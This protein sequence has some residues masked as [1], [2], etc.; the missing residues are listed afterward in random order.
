M[1]QHCHSTDDAQGAI[2]LLCHKHTQTEADDAEGYNAYWAEC[3]N[4]K[5]AISNS[6]SVQIRFGYHISSEIMRTSVLA[7]LSLSSGLFSRHHDLFGVKDLLLHV[8]R[9]LLH[10]REAPGRDGNA[11]HQRIFVVFPLNRSKLKTTHY[12]IPKHIP[13]RIIS[14]VLADMESV[15]MGTQQ[16][17]NQ[18]QPEQP[19]HQ[20]DKD[21]DDET[22][23]QLQ[24]CSVHYLALQDC[25]VENNRSWKSCQNGKSFPTFSLIIS[26]EKGKR[27]KKR[28]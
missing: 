24:E 25:L 4:Y 3:C 21:E 27:R 28:K 18:I 22:V 17:R 13:N 2:T 8:D 14:S 12:Q 26:S 7:A 11:L 10:A 6:N 9:D 16:N 23:K 15:T 19:L 1:M 20:M 5:D